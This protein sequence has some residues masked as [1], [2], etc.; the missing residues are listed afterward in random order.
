MATPEKTDYHEERLL[1]QSTLLERAHL[2]SREQRLVDIA[3]Q[4]AIEERLMHSD[5]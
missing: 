5:D 1:D 3:A 2:T 4:L